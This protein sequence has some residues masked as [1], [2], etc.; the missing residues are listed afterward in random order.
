MEKINFKIVSLVCSLMVLA[1][2]IQA[3]DI[4]G[5]VSLQGETFNFELSGQKNWDYDIKRIKEKGQSKVQLY[6]KPLDTKT[7]DKIKNIENPFVKSI[8]VVPKAIDGKTLVE[9]TLKDDEV[10]TFDYLTDQPSKLIVDFYQSEAIESDLKSPVQLKKGSGSKNSKD[11]SAADK[12]M[13]T[14]TA[15]SGKSKVA[16]RQPADIDI[17]QMSPGGIETSIISQ[18]GLYDGGDSQFSRFSMREGEYKEEAVIR[19]QS[20]YYLRFPTLE[21]E[22]QFWGKMK[23]NPP[24]YEFSSGKTA[25]NKQ[26]RLLKT[27]FDKKRFLV[28]KK[29]AEWFQSKYPNSPYLE[30]IAYMT[31]DALI[32]LWKLEKNDVIYE[33]GQ[34]AY[35]QALKSYPDSTL[36]ERTSLM[37][38]MLAIEKLDYMS[39]IRHLSAHAE[40]KRYENKISQQYAKIGLAFSFSKLNKLDEALAILTKLQKESKD[41]LVLASSSVRMGDFYFHSN[42]FN[43]AINAY[44]TAIKNH[45]VVKTLFPSAY[46]NKM[47]AQFWVKKYK[48]SHATALDFTKNFPVHAFAP[49]ALTRV[50]ELLDVMGADQSKSVG[51][52]LETHFRY[53]DSPKTIVA[54]LHLLSTRMKSMKSEELDETLKKMDALSENS[55]LENIDQFKTAMLADGFARRNDFRRAIEILS[56]FYQQNPSR[57]DSK[58]V[59]Q[60]IIRNIN[61]E[62]KNLADN[63][64]FKELLKTY[65]VYADTWLKTQTRIDTDYLLGLAYENAGAYKISDEKFNKTLV[66]LNEI[67]GTPLEKVVRVNEYLP[68][69]DSLYLKIAMDSFENN[70]FQNAYQTLEKIKN[71]MLLS[72]EEQVERIILASKLYEQ[73]GDTETSIRYLAELSRLWK[74]SNDLSLP[75]LVRLADMQTKHNSISD[76]LAT[77][78]KAFEV[79][80][81]QENPEIR[82]L[83]QIS[84]YYSDLLVKQNRS[85]EAAE[86]LSQTIQKFDEKYKLSEEKFQLGQLYFKK[87]EIKKAEQS[88][89][90]IPNDEK[91]IWKKLAQEKLQ[92]STW[93]ESYKKHIKRIPAM[94]QMEDI[95]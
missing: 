37:T 14:K 63:K 27:L 67:K 36:A 20:N 5:H 11:L 23:E 55:E 68:S 75:A 19:S 89:A 9:F 92:Q 33:Q 38:G 34:A 60:R 31:G 93:D 24:L 69:I 94:S 45:E 41:P 72:E 90:T 51:A 42:K 58:Q 91:E 35:M 7:I 8:Q 74:G 43:E 39:A 29:T 56:H 54:R 65:K 44:E 66:R 6:V 53:G 84:R 77:Y 15:K 25:E 71:P 62:L 80:L 95:K 79:I 48:D 59:T 30:M 40:N 76:A 12:K 49:Y 16:D 85:E 87:G 21:S 32:E 17:L 57:A 61:D 82:F 1:G 73:K 13:Q 81:K 50:G 52:Y 10:E 28:F 46:F 3:S 78:K 86:M 2:K 18:S 88:W 83:K 47:E 22:F 70:N 64:K 26:A 4:Q